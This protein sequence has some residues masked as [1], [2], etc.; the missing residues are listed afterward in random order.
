MLVHGS[1]RRV[2]SH[3]QAVFLVAQEERDRPVQRVAK[4][5]TAGLLAS[6]QKSQGRKAD[7]ARILSHR[8]QPAAIGQLASRKVVQPV[9]HGGGDWGGGVD[10]FEVPHGHPLGFSCWVLGNSRGRSEGRQDNRAEFHC[11]SFVGEPTSRMIFPPAPAG[12]PAP[13][14]ETARERPSL[15]TSPRALSPRAGTNP[16]SGL[17]S[18]A[19]VARRTRRGHA[20]RENLPLS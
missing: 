3:E 15:P 2:G 20:T 5:P 19:R 17:A 1:M 4:L 10:F 6:G 8:G 16:A 7:D 9:V 11:F 14:G 12:T 13:V 18:Q